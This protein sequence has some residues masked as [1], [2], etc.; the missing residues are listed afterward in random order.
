[1][2]HEIYT[3]HKLHLL[4]RGE[5]R[6]SLGQVE[7]LA[8]PTMDSEAMTKL[9]SEGMMLGPGWQ[10]GQ[11]LHALAENDARPPSATARL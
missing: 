9:D 7:A 2:H 10:P 4:R 11:L 3:P 8:L 5:G 6:E 1:M